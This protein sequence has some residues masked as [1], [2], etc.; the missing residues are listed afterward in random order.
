MKRPSGPRRIV[1]KKPVACAFSAAGALHPL[2]H[3]FLLRAFRI[4]VGAGGLGRRAGHECLVVIQPR[5]RSLVQHEGVKP[6]SAERRVIARE[7]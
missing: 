2:L 3:F 1:V 7:A 6:G 4:E 5:P